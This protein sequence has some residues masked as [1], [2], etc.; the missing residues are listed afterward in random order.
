M[1]QP[2]CR[3]ISEFERKIVDVTESFVL[4]DGRMK[5]R[6]RLMSLRHQTSRTNEL[7]EHIRASKLIIKIPI[8]D[9]A[10]TYELQDSAHHLH[11][12]CR[13]DKCN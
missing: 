3:D 1:N 13:R 7:I 2:C 12:L 11:P 6:S 10:I 4:M 5:C 8:L 9:I